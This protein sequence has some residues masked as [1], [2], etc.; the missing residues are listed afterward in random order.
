MATEISK[1]ADDLSPFER[2]VAAIMAVPKGAIEKA[3]SK[4]IK[5]ASRKIKQP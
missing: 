4:R 2:F 5:R 1:P 3:E